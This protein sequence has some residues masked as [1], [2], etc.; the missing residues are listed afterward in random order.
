MAVISNIPKRF[1]EGFKAIASIDDETFNRIVDGFSY[2]SLKPSIR[3]LAITIATDKSLDFDEVEKVLLSAGSLVPL[4]EG[5]IPIPDLLDSI[6]SLINKNRFFDESGKRE[7]FTERLS[8]LLQ[9]KQLYYAFK[10]SDL[11]TE[12]DN[13]F[14][15]SRVVSDIRPIFDLNVEGAPK[16]GII[17]HNLHIHYQSGQESEHKDIYFALDSK[18]INGLIEILERAKKKEIALQSIFEKTGMTNINA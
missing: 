18:D 4:L 1:V 7:K 17:I 3:E 14:I 6:S 11:V 16:A 10:A 12:N 13:T 5:G 8:V 15:Q 9:N 2:T